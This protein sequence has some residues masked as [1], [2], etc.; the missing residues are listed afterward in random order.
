MTY[1][2]I[3]VGV[4]LVLLRDG[5]VLMSQRKVDHNGLG[6][7]GG[8]GGALRPGESLTDSI[9][10]ELAEECGPDVVVDKLRM[11]CAINYRNGQ[12]PIHWV[13]IGFCA[14]YVS[15]DIKTMEPEKHVGWEWYTLNDLPSP[16]Y[17]PMARYIE[18]YQTGGMLYEL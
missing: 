17:W 10:R 13:G 16:L 2:N 11:V 3:K 7:Y 1:D 4:G 9:L 12:S 6:E 18:A 8:P 14:E 5:Q 15:G